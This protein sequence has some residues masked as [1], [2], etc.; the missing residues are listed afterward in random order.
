M[1]PLALFLVACATVFLGTVQAAFSALMRLVAA[2]HGRARRARRRAR[3]ISRRPAA[4][5]H[6]GPRRI[7]LCTVLAAVLIARVSDIDSL[8]AVATFVV[9]LVAFVVA[10]EHLIPMAIVGADP[11]RVL[12]VLL[13]VFNPLARLMTPLTATLLQVRGAPRS[14]RGRGRGP[15]AS[16]QPAHAPAGRRQ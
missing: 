5:L 7:G 14:R 2:A 13:P 1:T 15:T 4:A 6:P 8:Q 9:S 16:A 10:C 3:R 12:D 11:E